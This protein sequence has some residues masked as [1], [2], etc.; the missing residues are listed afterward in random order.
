MK[1]TLTIDVDDQEILAILRKFMT[2]TPPEASTPPAPK[3]EAP[4]VE[5][6]KVE[7]SHDDLRAACRAARQKGVPLGVVYSLMG[8]TKVEQV[9][10]NKIAAVIA[11]LRAAS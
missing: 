1:L 9:P 2:P 6:P 10:A 11:G 3:V 5:A 8:A 4:K 7:A